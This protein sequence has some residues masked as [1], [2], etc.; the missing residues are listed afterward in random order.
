MYSSGNEGH[1]VTNAEFIDIS[2]YTYMYLC[3][4]TYTVHT[5]SYIILHILH[6]VF[7]YVYF[8]MLSREGQ[9]DHRRFLCKKERTK[10]PKPTFLSFNCPPLV[11]FYK[12]TTAGV[13]PYS[14]AV[15][16]DHLTGDQ[17]TQGQTCWSTY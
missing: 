2:C 11:P 10:E 16:S 4:I 14:D 9:V 17:Q 15:D 13:Y 5:L 3:Y 8:E 12:E 1:K 7:R 6:K